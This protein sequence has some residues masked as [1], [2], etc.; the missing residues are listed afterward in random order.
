VGN[1]R[2]SQSRCKQETVESTID[3]ANMGRIIVARDPVC[4]MTIDEHKAAGESKCEGK[5]YHFCAPG[6][7]KA[8]D[9]DPRQYLGDAE[10]QN[11][12]GRTERS[13]Q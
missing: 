9:K 3:Q 5:T 13:N 4:G 2:F 12:D 7:K 10:K 11:Y 6:C 8:F 1:R